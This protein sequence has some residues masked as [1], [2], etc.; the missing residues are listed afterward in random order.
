MR[1]WFPGA[2]RRALH[3]AADLGD[4]AG[5]PGL[6]VQCKNQARDQLGQWVDVAEVQRAN[7]G[8]RTGVVVHKRRGRGRAADQFVTLPLRDFCALYNH[9]LVLER[10]HEG[11]AA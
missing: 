3:G 2:E 1:A 7:A 5:I 8:V 10:A 4:V 6:V 11:G 9:T